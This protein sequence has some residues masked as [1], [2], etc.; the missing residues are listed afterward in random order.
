MGSTL[1]FSHLQVPVHIITIIINIH[2][3]FFLMAI[4]GRDYECL[5][6]GVGT[7]GRV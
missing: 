6:A 7:N 2:I 4:V 1:K 3:T 5:Y